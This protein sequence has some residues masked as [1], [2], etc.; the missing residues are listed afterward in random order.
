MTDSQV[1]AGFSALD[2]SKFGEKADVPEDNAIWA[3]F[4][5]RQNQWHGI[6]ASGPIIPS[7]N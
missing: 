5:L 4:L 7:N 2:G 6:R 1:Q 3:D